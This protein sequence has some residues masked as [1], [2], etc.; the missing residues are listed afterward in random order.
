VR[1]ARLVVIV[2]DTVGVN[3]DA[4]HASPLPLEVRA[5]E[6]AVDFADLRLGAGPQQLVGPIEQDACTSLRDVAQHG[7]SVSGEWADRLVAGVLDA[8][9]LIQ[10]FNNSST[11]SLVCRPRN[12][13]TAAPFEAL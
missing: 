7:E 8:S 2:Q 13:T 1:H 5:S 11:C 3:P 10:T 12:T 4:G 6:R 9:R